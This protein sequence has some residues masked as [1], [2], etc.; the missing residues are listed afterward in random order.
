[1]MKRDTA[2]IGQHMYSQSVKK[3]GS[4]PRGDSRVI[5]FFE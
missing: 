2:G 4:V 3:F 5:R 1:M